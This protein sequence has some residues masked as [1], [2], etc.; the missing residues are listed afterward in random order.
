[1]V[2]DQVPSQQ[3]KPKFGRVNAL[4]GGIDH[5][6][7]DPSSGL[8]YV[9]YGVFDQSVGHNRLAIRRLRYEKCNEFSS[10]NVLV[11]GPRVFVDD[12]QSPAALPAVAV[13]ANGTVGVL[14]DTFEGM[15]GRCAV[16]GITSSCPVFVAH[17]A[18]A[19]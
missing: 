18:L 7:V 2:I 1:M 12:G 11:A 3:P 9:V 5:L 13:A 10:C 17:L 4:F 14:Y 6:A 16:A 15:F 19:D 8:V